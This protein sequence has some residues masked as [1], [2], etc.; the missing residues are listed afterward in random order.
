MPRE[1]IHCAILFADIAGSTRLFE[2]L[3]DATARRAITRCLDFFSDITHDSGGV[4]VKT[5]GDEIMSRFPTADA[6]MLA[7]CQMQVCLQ[8]RE[9]SFPFPIAVRIGFN[10]GPVLIERGDVFG[11]AVNLAA[12]MV[13]IAR[14]RQ[15]ITTEDSIR[16]CAVD[17]AAKARRFDRSKVRGK[18][19]LITM[20]E[21]L[22]ENE[23]VT[24]MV[25]SGGAGL[26]RFDVQIT[27]RYRAKDT[28]LKADSEGITLGRG[29]QCGL[30]VNTHLASRVH[31]R[32]MY[33]RGKFILTDE[34]TNGTFVRPTERRE[35]YLKREECPLSG[36]GVIS[37]GQSSRIDSADLI[38]FSSS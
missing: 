6:A 3:G 28:V 31:A 13:S 25:E 32:I 14:A 21:V 18:A 37:L 11:D 12:R 5:I 20:Y 29:E 26:E 30:L 4:V 8:E 23:N 35:I 2:T 7:A 1:S 33:R 22:W 36:T 10:Y 15:I 38:Q 34:S 27:L 9:S 16:R 24:H 19:D 17:L